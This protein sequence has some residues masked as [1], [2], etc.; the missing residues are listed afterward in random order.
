MVIIK[1]L[2]PIECKNT[3]LFTKESIYPTYFPSSNNNNAFFN[4]KELISITIN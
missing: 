4:T 2:N 3:Y 1:R